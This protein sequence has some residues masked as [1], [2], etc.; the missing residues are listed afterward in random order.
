VANLY[1][2]RAWKDRILLPLADVAHRYRVTPNVVTGLGLLLGITSGVSL[3][4]RAVPFALLLL[5]VSVFCDVL[6]GAVARTFH[7]KT[8]FG[9]AFDSVADRCTEL[10]VVI[11]A[12]FSGI[13][14]P[15]GCVA[16][17]GSITLLFMRTLSYPHGLDTDYVLF[18]RAER[19]V[20]ISL[21][22]I[23]SSISISTFCFVMAG[24]FGLL[25]SYQVGISLWHQR[26][27]LFRV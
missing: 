16:I 7:L 9:L 26:T 13:I 15:I 21:G 10:S 25:S 27:S 20:F 12:L 18:G 1:C 5:L 6:D 8:T 11:G 3:A 22:L 2:M 24:V 17:I 19:I 4:H 14:H 23:A